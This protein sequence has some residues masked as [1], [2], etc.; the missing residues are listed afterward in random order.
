VDFPGKAE[1]LQKVEE[2]RAKV[3]SGEIQVPTSP[4]QAAAPARP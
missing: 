1:A 4:T 2:L 3:I